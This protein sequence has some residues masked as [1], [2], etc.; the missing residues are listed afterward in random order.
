MVSLGEGP[1]KALEAVRSLGLSTCQLGLGS[2]ERFGPE[3]AAEIR[4]AAAK[5]DVEITCC[6][7]RLPGRMTWNF[8]DGPRTIGL[9]PPATRAERIKHFKLASDFARLLDVPALAAHMGFIPE[10]AS[11]PEYAPVVEALRDVATHCRNNSQGVWFE[12]GQETPIALFRAIQ[13]IGTD[14]LGINLDPAN[15][16]MYGKAN[17]VDALDILGPLVRGVHAKD[18]EYPTN[19]RELGPEKPLGEGRVNFPVLVPKLKAFGFTGA[20]TIEREVRGAEQIAGIK[21]AISILQLL[22]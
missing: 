21:Q 11:D 19:G 9:V 14:N 22:L 16:L 3:L 6:W 13:D 12:T 8:A 15:L 5:W 2:A 18:G 10:N 17:P 7:P 4:L 20:L 1:D